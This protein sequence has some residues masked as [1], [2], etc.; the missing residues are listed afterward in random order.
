MLADQ[1]S[2]D[3]TLADVFMYCWNDKCNVWTILNSLKKNFLYMTRAILDAAIVWWEGVPSSQFE[4][5]DQWHSIS[6][7]TGETQ[8]ELIKQTISFSKQE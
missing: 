6:R 8:A 1:C 7:Q 4:N 2:I 5:L 3:S